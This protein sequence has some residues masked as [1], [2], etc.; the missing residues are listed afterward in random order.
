LIHNGRT[1]AVLLGAAGLNYYA[2]H[3]GN[4]LV[5]T[6]GPEFNK[7]DVGFVFP[8]NSSLRKRVNS[9]LLTIREDGTRSCRLSFARLRPSLDRLDAARCG[10]CLTFYKA[11][12]K[13]GKV[14]WPSGY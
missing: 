2:S 7:N 10:S 1:D 11:D 8:A 9:A 13:N 5:T 14:T 6:V 3:Y 4:G 12:V